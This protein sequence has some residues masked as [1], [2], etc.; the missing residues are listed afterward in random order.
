[1]LRSN[2]RKARELVCVDSIER[3][4]GIDEIRG[5]KFH[6]SKDCDDDSQASSKEDFASKRGSAELV[7]RSDHL[8]IKVLII[9]EKI[10]EVPDRVNR[11]I[12]QTRFSS[13]SLSLESHR[14]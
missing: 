12:L 5:S 6:A 3:K 9:E 13:V 10:P 2:S 4:E 14:K 1:M 8:A 7:A 11:T